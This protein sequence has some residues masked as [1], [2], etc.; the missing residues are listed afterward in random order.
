VGDGDA[1]N[2]DL[3]VEPVQLSSDLKIPKC[4]HMISPGDVI[5]R[6]EMYY[7]GGALRYLAPG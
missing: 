6:I 2:D 7:Q 5:R 3:C 1:K 4:M